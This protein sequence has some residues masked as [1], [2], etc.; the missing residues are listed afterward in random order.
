MVYF[1]SLQKLRAVAALCVVCFHTQCYLHLICGKSGTVFRVFDPRFRYGAWFFFALSG[2]LMAFLIDAG[3]GRFLVRRL[4]RI[5]PS[6]WLAVASTI[7]LKVLLFGSVSYPKLLVGMSLLPMGRAAPDQKYVLL[8][9]WTLIYEVFFYAACSAFALGRLRRAFP[10]FLA[11]WAA[12]LV[13]ANYR[14]TGTLDLL[15]LPSWRRVATSPYNL[16]FV[17]GALSF[18]LSRHLGGWPRLAQAGSAAVA[19]GAFTATCYVR[20]DGLHAAFMGVGFSAIIVLATLRD[21]GRRGPAPRPGLLERLGDHS[22]GLY[23][24]HGSVITIVMAK[25]SQDYGLEGSHFLGAFALAAALAVGWYFGEV[26]LMI[27]RALKRHFGKPR[28]EG[29]G[30][31]FGPAFAPLGQRGRIPTRRSLAAS[32]GTPRL[33]GGRVDAGEPMHDAPRRS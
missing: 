28:Q 24:V 2:F 21:R 22:Y 9:E 15:M 33:G 8:V 16:L 4:A 14:A 31:R 20:S 1:G 23:L 26:D 32:A 7:V 11:A 3:S 19:A 5:Y 25:A 10:Y 12:V 27:H 17:I 6:F 29:A 18:H 13:A 30:A